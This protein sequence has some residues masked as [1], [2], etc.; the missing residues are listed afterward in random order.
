MPDLS[1]QVESV[2]SVRC[3]AAPMLN[4]KLHIAS[5]IAGDDIANVILQCQIQIEAPRRRYQPAE[6]ERLRELFGDPNSASQKIHSL[7]W[8]HVGLLVPRFQN[9]CVVDMPVPCSYDFNAAAVKFFYAL[10]DGKV[11][12]LFQFSGTIF[13][14]DENTGLQ[15]SRIAWSKEAQFSLPVPVWQEMMDHYYPNSAWLRLDRNQFDRLYQYKRQHGLSSW[16][17]AVESLLDGV[18]E[19]LP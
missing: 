8:T 11:P 9:D 12:L 4:F 6:Q 5:A 1:F 16:E 10:E 18:E 15:I 7:L 17:Q 19:N 2:E 13:Y 3:A 14:R